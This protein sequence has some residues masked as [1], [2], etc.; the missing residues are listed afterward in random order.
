MK[1]HVTMISFK[2]ACNIRL[3]NGLLPLVLQPGKSPLA[4]NLGYVN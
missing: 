3:D 1:L 4:I 2:P